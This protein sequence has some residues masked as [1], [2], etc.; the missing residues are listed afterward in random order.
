MSGHLDTKD[1]ILAPYMTDSIETMDDSCPSC[2][3][4][5]LTVFPWQLKLCKT[6]ILQYK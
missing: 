2:C 1:K 4:T 6:Y 3:Q 5:I